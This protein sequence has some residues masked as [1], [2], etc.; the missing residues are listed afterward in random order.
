MTEH[1]LD[2]YAAHFGRALL[3]QHGGHRFAQT[4]QDA[5]L[6][7]GDDGTA[8]PRRLD[9]QFLVQRLD[10]AE[11]DDSGLD[12]LVFQLFSDG[13]ASPTSRPVAKIATSLPSV[14]CS[15]LPI[16]NLKV[17]SSWNTGTARRPNRR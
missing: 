16:S 12:A 14:S 15:P 10:G 3:A 1:I 9:D 5:V 13:E 2:A 11:V 17:A 7:A 4:T 6:L 8:L